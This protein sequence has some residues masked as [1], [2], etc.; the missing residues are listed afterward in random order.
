MTKTDVKGQHHGCN[1]NYGTETQ[2]APTHYR[3]DNND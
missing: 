1:D 2:P 3:A